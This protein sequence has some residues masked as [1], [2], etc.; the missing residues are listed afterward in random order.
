[1]RCEVLIK[2]NIPSLQVYYK[3]LRAC[4]CV[5]HVFVVRVCVCILVK[6]NRETCA[7][8]TWACVP[9]DAPPSLFPSPLP[10][11]LSPVS[12]C[13]SLCCAVH[14]RVLKSS[15]RRWQRHDQSKQQQ[16]T[17]TILVFTYTH[18]YTHTYKH[19]DRQT[20]RHSHRH[21]QNLP[22]VSV[23]V[24]V[25]VFKRVTTCVCVCVLGGVHRTR[26]TLV[27]V[28]CAMLFCPFTLP[29]SCCCSLTL[30]RC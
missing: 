29:M 10:L 13:V 30:W 2:V 7:S 18:T 5:S 12:H 19:K 14:A 21:R 6:I 28:S 8:Y 15:R 4:V 24:C 23:W 16:Q 22:F 26:S 27:S 17:T 9:R 11:S 20:G 25:C 1:M 3:H